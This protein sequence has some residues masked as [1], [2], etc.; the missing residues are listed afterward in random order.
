MFGGH[1][2]DNIKSCPWCKEPVRYT[3]Y[4]ELCDFDHNGRLYDDIQELPAERIECSNVHCPIRPNLT[5]INTNDAIKIWNT[6]NY[7]LEEFQK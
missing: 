7:N 4:F 1:N 5:R 6:W 3:K 2:L